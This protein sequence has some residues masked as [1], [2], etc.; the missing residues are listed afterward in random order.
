MSELLISAEDFNTSL[1]LMQDSA[2]IGE[3]AARVVID[4]KVEPQTIHEKYRDDTEALISALEKEI[5]ISREEKIIVSTDSRGSSRTNTP[6]P[7]GNRNQGKFSYMSTMDPG[8]LCEG[9]S[10]NDAYK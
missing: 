8:H 5:N 1:D 2:F 7:M 3:A 4:N 10:L 9:I 6:D